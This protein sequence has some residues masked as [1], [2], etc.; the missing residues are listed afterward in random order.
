MLLPN[1]YVR[2][3]ETN[4]TAFLIGRV[5]VLSPLG[6]EGVIYVIKEEHEGQYRIRQ[7]DVIDVEFVCLN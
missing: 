1:A 2:V 4:E 7:V 6:I 5:F 3:L